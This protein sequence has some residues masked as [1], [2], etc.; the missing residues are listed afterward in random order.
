MESKL[1]RLFGVLW[2]AL[3]ASAFAQDYPAKPVRIIVPSPGGTVDVVTRLVAEKLGAKW[4]QAVVVENRAG[5]GGNIGA[6]AVARSAP[7]GYTLL[8][9]PP[10]PLAINKSLYA[11]LS[12]DPDAFVPIAILAT[13]PSVL[14][15]NQKV[16]AQSLAQLLAFAKANP[17][18]LNYASAGSG[19]S[20]HLAAEM[21]RS[22]A[23]INIVHVPYKGAGAAL[24]DVTAGQVDMMFMDLGAVLPQVRAGKL[25]ALAVAS[26][27]RN[28][29]LPDV[30]TVQEAVPGFLSIFWAGLVGPAGTPSTAVSR[31]AAG[32]AEALKQ[33]DVTKRLSELSL[34]P[35][36]GSR[37]DVLLFLRQERERWSK[38]IRSAGITAD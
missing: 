37:D 17:G 14:V 5:A 4:G 33:P 19:S 26:G 11:K 15:V 1:R 25:R 18:K 12:Y 29:Q 24:T 10:G 2:I 32:T 20:L 30:P 16:P 7:D 35:Y 34:E 8:A 3:A 31:I 38:V 23:G 28:A 22:M 9:S 13:A 27:K 36:E 6:D 21:F